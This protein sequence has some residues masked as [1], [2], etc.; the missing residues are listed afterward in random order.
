VQTLTLVMANL[1]KIACGDAFL[2]AFGHIYR[3]ILPRVSWAV[4]FPISG[5]DGEIEKPVQSFMAA[6]RRRPHDPTFPS[7]W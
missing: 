7:T 4:L 1:R 3:G 5:Q 6:H 2:A